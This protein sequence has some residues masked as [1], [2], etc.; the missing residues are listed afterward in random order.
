MSQT[1]RDEQH[2]KSLRRPETVKRDILDV[3]TFDELRQYISEDEVCDCNLITVL[4]RARKI[5]DKS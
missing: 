3:L 2:R 4:H 1:D 5:V